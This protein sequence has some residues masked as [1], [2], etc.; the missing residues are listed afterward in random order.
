MI[1]YRGEHIGVGQLGH[2]LVILCFVTAVSSA[3]LCVIKSKINLKYWITSSVLA[4][5]VSV[6][7][8]AGVLIFMLLQHFY[9]YQYVWQHSNSQMDMRYI[10]S[11]LW[12]GQEGSFLLWLFWNALL[13][14]GVWY[15]LRNSPLLKPVLSILFLIQAFISSML[16]GVYVLDYKIGSSPFLLLREHP[17]F[18]NLP[19]VKSPDYLTHLD[20]RGLNP[21]LMNAWMTIHPPTLFLGFALTGIPFAFALSGLWQSLKPQTWARAAYPWAIAAMAVLGI[22]ILMGGA[23]AY[24]ALSFGGFWAWDPVEN[25]S[26][27]PWLLMVVGVHA[28]LLHLRKKGSSASTYLG[29]ILPFLTVLYSTFLTRSGILG[30]ASVHAF[31]D[32]GMTGQLLIY[33][34]T[35]VYLAV[36]PAISNS[37]ARTAYLVLSPLILFMGAVY[38]HMPWGFWIWMSY[39]LIHLLWMLY[40][41]FINSETHSLLSNRSGFIRI[42]MLWMLITSAMIVFFTSVPVINTLFSKR[43]APPSIDTYNQWMTPMV[44]F[45]LF[46]MTWA[47]QLSYAKHNWLQVFNKSAWWSGLALVISCCVCIP[48]YVLNPP[49]GYYGIWYWQLALIVLVIVCIWGL[50]LHFRE[51]IR[52]KASLWIETGGALA[53]MGFILVILGALLS[54]SKKTNLSSR[55]Q[56]AIPGIKTNAGSIMLTR[57]DTVQMGPYWVTYAKKERKG[58]DVFFTVHY[59]H[60]TASQQYVSAFTLQPKVQDNPRMGKAAD[61]DTK[62]FLSHDVYTHVSYADLSDEAEQHKGYSQPFNTVG[63]IGDTISLRQYLLILDS[64]RTQMVSTDSVMRVTMV[65]RGLDVKGSVFKA[66]PTLDIKNRMLIPIPYELKDKGIKLIFWNIKPEEQAFEITVQENTA[67][68]S[69]FIVMEAYAFPFINIL[70]TGVIVMALGTFM[71]LFKYI[72]KSSS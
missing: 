40:L 71:T 37:I 7:A 5:A 12:E 1:P 16:L 52:T 61:P 25:S 20:G 10:F 2:V 47:H 21:L 33:L 51:I 54:T 19:F 18:M 39:T 44:M 17:D 32:L 65:L 49:K 68:Q 38:E 53:H 4:H 41:R 28:L 50:A 57:G 67:L 30:N 15:Q 31:T 35:F 29:T 27:V 36:A 6:S 72:F 70:W 45:I 22:G 69:D 63:H 64:I 14:I 46:L 34:L 62:H 23:W 66:Y 3:L 59:F 58:M 8:V 13:G 42:G 43:Y 11:C 9:E 60:K 24:E 56:A 26:L 55:P 48:F